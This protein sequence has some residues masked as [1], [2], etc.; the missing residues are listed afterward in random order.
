[1]Y[2]IFYKPVNT[3]KVPFSSYLQVQIYSTFALAFLSYGTRPS[4]TRYVFGREIGRISFL[5]GL[6]YAFMK[7][8]DT[9][10]VYAPFTTSIHI[11][12]SYFAGARS[13]QSYF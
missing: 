13:S 7:S 10:P 12:I 5:V 8:T 6:K 9:L 11:Q 4:N 2:Q 3:P 1:M